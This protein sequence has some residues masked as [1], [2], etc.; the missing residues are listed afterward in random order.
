MCFH[1]GTSLVLGIHLS[2]NKALFHQGPYLIGECFSSCN[3]H[4]FTSKCLFMSM[5]MTMGD[6]PTSKI[7]YTQLILFTLMTI[8]CKVMCLNE[9]ASQVNF[10]VMPRP[11]GRCLEY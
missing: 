5:D 3:R 8:L 1:N 7:Q 10:T 4:H 6:A 9:D 2:K 11:I